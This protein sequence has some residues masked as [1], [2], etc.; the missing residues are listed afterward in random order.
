MLGRDNQGPNYGKGDAGRKMKTGLGCRRFSG[1]GKS[2]D[3]GTGESTGEGEGQ[4]IGKRNDGRK[5][6]RYGIG[7]EGKEREG[8]MERGWRRRKTARHKSRIVDG[9]RLRRGWTAR[10]WPGVGA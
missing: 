8:E 9:E 1:E 4:G 10:D 5:G 2:T 7:P 6:R 3:K